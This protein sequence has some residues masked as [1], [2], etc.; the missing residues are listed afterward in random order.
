MQEAATFVSRSVLPSCSSF[1]PTVLWCP[2]KDL[3]LQ[4]LVCRTSA[5]SVELLGRN[6]EAGGSG[7]KQAL[8]ET[9]V[10]A[11]C[12]RLLLTVF[13]VGVGIEPTSRVFQTRANPSQLS[14]PVPVGRS[15]KQEAEPQ[16]LLMPTAP[17]PILSVHARPSHEH[18]DHR[19]CP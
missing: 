19:A 11:Y 3:N 15:S 17:A 4:P 9:N 13:L 8:R 14:D 12:S 18:P 6:Q 7:S 2:R 10:T 16:S 1:L 5:P